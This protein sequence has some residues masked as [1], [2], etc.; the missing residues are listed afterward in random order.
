MARNLKDLAKIVG[1]SIS[2]DPATSFEGAASIEKASGKDLTFALE[3]RSVPVADRSDAAAMIAPSG[4]SP[5]KPAI[6]VDNPRLAMA[7][8]LKL[9]EKKKAPPVKDLATVGKGSSIGKGTVLH[10]GVRIGSG[11]TVGKECEIHPNAVIYDGVTI[12]NR[13]IIH[14]GAVIGVDGFGF[15][16]DGGKHVKIPQIGSVVIEDDVEIYANT[17][18]A[19]GTLGNTIIRRGTKIDNITHIA[20]NCDIGEDCALTAL[21]G[22]AGGVTLEKSVYVGGQAGFNGHITVGENTVVMAK[23]GVTKDIPKNSFISGFPAQDHKKEMEFQVRL[24][25]LAGK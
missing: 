9:Y 4:T 18:I 21:I 15:A 7:K 23:S 22:F 2:G 3:K 25:K 11:V 14:A 24:R 1:G 8:V 16:Q 10:P 19:R 20:H 5:K 13:V 6:L 12:G 17:C